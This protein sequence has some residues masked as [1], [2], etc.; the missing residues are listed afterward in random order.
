MQCY[1]MCSTH[2]S[3]VTGC[4]WLSRLQCINASVLV[5]RLCYLFAVS[6]CKL[7]YQLHERQAGIMFQCVMLGRWE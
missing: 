2:S 7:V 5:Q 6:C 1:I 4:M 3:L